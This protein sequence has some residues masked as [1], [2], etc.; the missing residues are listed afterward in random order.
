[1]V[2]NGKRRGGVIAPFAP[3]LDVSAPPE[4]GRERGV[5]NPEQL[6]LAAANA[7]LMNTHLAFARKLAIEV[8]GY[9][10]GG[11]AE[12]TPDPEGG[13]AITRV[14]LSPVVL[15]ARQQD[16]ER[17]SRLMGTAERNCLV[18]RSLRYPVRVRPSVRAWAPGAKAGVPAA[19]GAR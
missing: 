6:L 4:F 16:V 2:W 5:W 13:F 8:V 11:R 14:A 15:I 12:L 9:S 3:P 1:M 7:C 19:P 10:C 17:A 18:G